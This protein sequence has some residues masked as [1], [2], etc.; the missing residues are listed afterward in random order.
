VKQGTF[1]GIGVGPGDPEL[2]TVKAASVLA[3]CPH[4]FVPKARTVSES[5]ALE[6]TRRYL[7]SDAQVQELVFPMTP[8]QDLLEQRW[9]ESAEVIASVLEAGNDAC[10]LT[11]GDPM[12][13][14]T[15]I[16]LL[17][18]LDERL[19]GVTTITVPGITSF[20]AAAAAT[21]FALGE[22]KELITI[23][24]TSDDLTVLR[25]ALSTQGTVVLMK[26]GKRLREILEILKESGLLEH[27]VF[28]SRVGQGRQHIETDLRK[29]CVQDPE[30][31]YL[32]VIIVHASRR[33]EK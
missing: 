1:Y 10:F 33:S 3:A 16:Y 5:V 14:S 28:V 22:G 15:Y 7:R 2:L 6:I 13:Y 25:R 19:P 11:L 32:S 30:A 9:R 21:H 4:V 18:A 29:L 23:V 26:I 24:P 20:C 27:S 31:G 17:R 8:D 12:V